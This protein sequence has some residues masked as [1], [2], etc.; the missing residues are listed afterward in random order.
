MVNAHSDGDGTFILDH[1]RTSSYKNLRMLLTSRLPGQPE[2]QLEPYVGTFFVDRARLQERAPFL[3]WLEV[4]KEGT[5]TTK[6]NPAEEFLL[7][8]PRCA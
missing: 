1:I 2:L 4:P 8:L 5:R 7:Y 3:V 6:L